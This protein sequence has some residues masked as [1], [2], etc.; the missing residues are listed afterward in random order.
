MPTGHGRAGLR[1]DALA[2]ASAALAAADPEAAL[3]RLIVL[4]G[5]ELLV[6]GAPW[7]GLQPPSA[8]RPA[9]ASGSDDAGQP[10]AAAIPL[11][12]RRI[13]VLGA[14]KATIGMASVL[15][16]VL[17]PRIAAGCVVVKRGQGRRLRHI[18]VVEAAHPVPDE[19]SLAG[20]RRLLELAEEAGPDDLALG[21]V[22]GGSSA[23]AVAPADGLTLAD[24]V[25]ANEVLLACGADIV[26]VNAVRKHLSRIKGGLLARACGCEIVNFTVSDV[27]GDPLDVVTDLLV[28]DRSTWHDAQAA[29]DRFGLWDRLPAT[30]AARLRAA[31]PDA[32]TPKA[33]TGVRTW[34]V[35]DAE[36]MCAA[37]AAKAEELGYRS[38]VLGL[39]FEGD[40]ADTGRMLAASIAGA[41]PHSCLIAGGENTVALPAGNPAAAGAGGPNQEAAL[42]AADV[43]AGGRTSS[44]PACVL[45]IDSDGTDGPTDAAGGLV[46]DLSAT[47]A[48]SA[49][50]DLRSALAAHIAGS[51]L[52]ALGD[53]VVTGPTGTNVNDLKVALRGD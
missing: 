3:R 22:T 21:L 10:A 49:G 25:A 23:L 37:A 8:G 9:D 50:V 38:R 28:P 14:G 19:G 45:C 35:A 30:V 47:V 40:A 32:E 6:R 27:V 7:L 51:A 2:I 33:I 20:G 53:L 26:A 39:D 41:P 43:L 11:L 46:D 42:A 15:D 13:I 52:A 36:R 16:E 29:C 12:G 24:K 18:E 48:S 17:G 4:K 1:T 44:A 34:I 31:D 5:D